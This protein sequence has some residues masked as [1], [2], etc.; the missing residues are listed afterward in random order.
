MKKTDNHPCIYIYLFYRTT[1]QLLLETPQW[2][3]MMKKCDDSK[4]QEPLKTLIVEMPG[5]IPDNCVTLDIDFHQKKC[6]RFCKLHVYVVRD[7]DMPPK[8]ASHLSSNSSNE[9]HRIEYHVIVLL[10]YGEKLL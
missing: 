3:A 6:S 4:L 1:V 2:K 9:Q 7:K 5:K 10:S 8:P